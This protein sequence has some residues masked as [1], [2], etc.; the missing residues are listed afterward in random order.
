MIHA[1]TENIVDAARNC[2]Y[3]AVKVD[4]GAC[5]KHAFSPS[6]VSIPDPM[7]I[8]YGFYDN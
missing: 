3:V 1:A 7:T 5:E 4:T 2:W 6:K 8:G